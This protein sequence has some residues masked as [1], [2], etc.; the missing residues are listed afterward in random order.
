MP[1]LKWP[2]SKLSRIYPLPFPHRPFFLIFPYDSQYHSTFT[3][4]IVIKLFSINYFFLFQN[5]KLQCQKFLNFFWHYYWLLPLKIDDMECLRGAKLFGI[6]SSHTNFNNF[7]KFLIYIAEVK[8][9]KEILSKKMS[10]WYRVMM[11]V[12]PY[13][14]QISK[15]CLFMSM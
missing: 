3:I 15:L 1:L 14:C 7:R 9:W 5:I 13:L 2:S 6:F 8:K 12:H 4:P 10:K 11:V